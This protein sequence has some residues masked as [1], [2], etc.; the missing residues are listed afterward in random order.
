M[1]GG[2][3]MKTL[4]N[5]LISALILTTILV[6]MADR[7]AASQ[8]KGNVESFY[9]G[10]TVKLNIPYAP[11]GNADIWGRALVPHL[12]KHLGAKVI[13]ENVPGAGGLVGGAQLYSLTKPDGLTVSI[14]LLTGLMLAEMLDLEAARFELNKFSYIGRIDLAWRFL[15]AS[16]SSGFKTIKDMQ[17]AP[18]TIRFGATEKISPSAADIAIMSEAFGLKSK[19]IPGYKATVEYVLATVAGREL[20]AISSIIVG[21]E[22][23]AEKGDLVMVLIQGNK[24]SPDYPHVPAISEI[25]TVNAE[26]KKLIEFLTA[27]G[28]AGRLVLLAPP[29]IPRRYPS[30][31]PGPDPFRLYSREC[32]VYHP[33][34]RKLNV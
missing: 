15:F 5:A 22:D 25:P 17:R 29:G 19:I 30:P 14:Q 4:K 12:E 8:T 27:L 3:T 13:V 11:G 20:D 32:P 28:E 9:K 1:N 26:G 31:N 18:K 33:D 16:K 2:G 6:G 23:Y 21:C 10:K 24:R 7:K 34:W